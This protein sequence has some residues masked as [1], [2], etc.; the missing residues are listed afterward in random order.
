MT[1]VNL[2]NAE[3]S[4]SSLAEYLRAIDAQ[5]GCGQTLEVNLANIS[6]SVNQNGKRPGLKIYVV[7]RGLVVV[8]LGAAPA[9]R[10]LGTDTLFEITPS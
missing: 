2:Q 6:H 8:A 7:D 1:A 5:I 3:A 4:G 10:W 9:D